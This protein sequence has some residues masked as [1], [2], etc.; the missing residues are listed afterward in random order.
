[1]ATGAEAMVRLLAGHNVKHIFG[2][3]GDTSLPFY[4][5][6]HQL[7]HGMQHILARDERS[8]AYMADVYA[9]LTNKMGVCE[10][11]SGGGATYILPGLVEAND[12]SSPVLAITTDVSVA[13]RGKFPLTELDQRALFAPV[14]KWNAMIDRADQLPLLVRTAFQRMVTGKPGSVHLGLPFDVQQADVPKQ[15]WCVDPAL[16]QVPARRLAPA[17]ADVEQMADALRNARQPVIICG[18]GP[19]IAGAF[20]EVQRLAELLAAPVA[21]SIS[22]QGIIADTHALALGVVGSNGG[23]PATR[24]VV[25]QADTVL[26]IGCRAGSV[27]TE[28]NRYPAPD[29][30]KILHIDIDPDVIGVNYATDVALLGDAKLA[31]NALIEALGNGADAERVQSAQHSVAQARQQKFGIFNELAT[32]QDG[33]IRPEAV[34]AAVQQ[35]APENTVIVADPGTPCPYFSAYYQQPQAGR[36]FVTNRAHGALGYALPGIIGAQ[37]ARPN[38]PCIAVMGDGSFGFACGELETL[39]RLQLP[40][41]L[42]VISNAVFGWIKAGQK[43]SFGERYFSVDFNRTDHA[44]VA[45]AFGVKSWRVESPAQL[46]PALKEALHTDGPA[47][48]DI[49]CQPLHEANAPV[50]EWVA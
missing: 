9:R 42:L 30:P 38:N 23:T 32:L 28:R 21:T 29:G 40:V 35:L 34:V 27:T 47:L 16:G 49:L 37:F 22:G 46:L 45:Q 19:I 14:T 43:H 48:V 11:P 6:L 24:A 33:L 44:R 20:A 2:L 41:T 3:C 36:Y 39:V 26:F 1:M 4:D 13:S 25:Q 12:S 7:N 31:L 18:S 10:G 5:A 8:A 15:D 50:A 17:V